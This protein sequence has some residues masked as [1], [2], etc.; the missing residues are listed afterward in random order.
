MTQISC[1]DCDAIYVGQTMRQLKIKISNSV[2]TEHRINFN[3]NFDWNNVKFEI[4]R[5]FYQND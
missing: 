2:I 3:H 5:N 1:K 4:K